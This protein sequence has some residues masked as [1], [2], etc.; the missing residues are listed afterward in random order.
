LAPDDAYFKLDKIYLI[1]MVERQGGLGPLCFGPRIMGEPA[2]QY[3]QLA[4][5][6]RTYNGST[7]PEDWLEDNATTVN[8]AGGNLRWAVSYVPHMLEGPAR[9]RGRGHWMNLKVKVQT[10]KA[11]L[12]VCRE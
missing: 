1:E 2:P 7:K 6:T 4:R 12:D 3:F 10:N 5:G 9:I 11:K 8:I